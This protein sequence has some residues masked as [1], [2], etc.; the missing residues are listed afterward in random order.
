MEDAPCHMGGVGHFVFLPIKVFLFM[1][2]SAFC[3][4]RKIVRQTNT[5]DGLEAVPA[6]MLCEVCL[7]Q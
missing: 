4:R 3:F 6:A 2:P 5:R 7:I 1:S